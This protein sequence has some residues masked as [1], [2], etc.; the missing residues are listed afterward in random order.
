MLDFQMNMSHERLHID[1][2]LMDKVLG[3]SDIANTLGQ[4]RN[5]Y[6]QDIL[7]V[8][9]QDTITLDRKSTWFLTP[10]LRYNRSR[11]LATA[12]GNDLQ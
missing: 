6:D 12:M 5:R 10:S 4:T 11:L 1:G 3:D 9:L 7:N 8:Q 2:S